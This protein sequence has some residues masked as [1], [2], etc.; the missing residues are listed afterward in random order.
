MQYSH[1]TRAQRLCTHPKVFCAANVRGIGIL[2][3]AAGHSPDRAQSVVSE[4]AGVKPD[5]AAGS[6]RDSFAAARARKITPSQALCACPQ[7]SRRGRPAS[8]QN[9]TAFFIFADTLPPP[10]GFLPIRININV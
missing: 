4:K 1:Y 2:L 10:G 3:P 5:T 9:R 8:P 6:V 7:P